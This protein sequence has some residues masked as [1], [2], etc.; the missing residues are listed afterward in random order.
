MKIEQIIFLNGMFIIILIILYKNRERFREL[1]DIE[2]KREIER[3]LHIPVYGRFGNN[4]IQITNAVK[5]GLQTGCKKITF[6]GKTIH[7][8]KSNKTTK[9]FSFITEMNKDGSNYF[10]EKQ[11]KNIYPNYDE[12]TVD[13]QEVRNILLKYC[14]DSY[15]FIHN[16]Y[17][18]IHIRSG[19]IFSE[20]LHTAYSQPP[21]DFYKMILELETF[22][23]N[24]VVLIAEDK[25]NPVI[26]K[27][28]ENYKNVFWEKNSLKRDQEIIMNSKYIV[29]GRGSFVPQLLY[30]SYGRKHVI[31]FDKDRILLDKYNNGFSEYQNKIMINNYIV[32][33]NNTPE[34][35]NIM[36]NFNIKNNC[37][38][39]NLEKL[40][41]EFN[42]IL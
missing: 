4:I 1:S 11:L 26:N 36:L 34:Q 32:D 39:A 37:D 10:Y 18:C 35:R 40:I 12:S 8:P 28:L 17:L 13:Q 30:L 6:N 9:N 3:E 27:I 19:D 38:K 21:Y 15:K 14:F 24:P 41:N 20:N 16:T 22:K 42:S 2:R 23:G 33:W 25:K 5:L 29:Y 7:L 31:C